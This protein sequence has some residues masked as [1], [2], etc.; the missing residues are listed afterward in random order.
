MSARGHMA[1]TTDNAS[2]RGDSMS[3]AKNEVMAARDGLVA[4]TQIIP[5]VADNDVPRAGA[6]DGGIIAIILIDG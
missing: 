6:F 3:L 2:V 1:N 5:L 4:S